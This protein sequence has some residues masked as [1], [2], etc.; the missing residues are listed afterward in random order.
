MQCT[1]S[2]NQSHS[3]LV[4][5][6]SEIAKLRTGNQRNDHRFALYSVVGSAQTNYERSKSVT[7][8]KQQRLIKVSHHHPGQFLQEALRQTHQAPNESDLSECALLRRNSQESFLKLIFLFL[9]FLVKSSTT[10]LERDECKDVPSE[11]LH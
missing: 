5:A 11:S 3:T 7:H 9:H 2:R 8:S 10:A 6:R 1:R 4:L